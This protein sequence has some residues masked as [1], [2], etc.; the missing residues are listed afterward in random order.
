MILNILGLKEITC[1][2]DHFVTESFTS[3]ID[4][5]W[6]K[7]ITYKTDHSVTKTGYNISQIIL[8]LKEVR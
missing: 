7:E 2:T 5:L 4:P 8:W 6:L 3:N 1:N